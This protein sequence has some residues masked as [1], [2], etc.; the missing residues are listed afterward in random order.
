MPTIALDLQGISSYT[1]YASGGMRE[2]HVDQPNVVHTSCGDLVPRYSRPDVRS[3]DMKSLSFYESGAIRS[4]C[5]DAQTM[6]DTPLG[7]FPAELVTFFE[8]GVLDSVFPLNGQIGFS[9]SQDDEKALADDFTFEF[10]F[11]SI[12]AKI[13]GVRFY[14]SGK[15]KSVILWPGEVVPV[16]TP[17]GV[18]QGRAGVRVFET[19]ELESFEPAAP[20]SLTTP[21]GPVMAYDVDALEMDADEN[22]VRFDA[23]GN[24]VRVATS[25]D[26]IANSPAVGHKRFSSRTRMALSKDVPVK[27]PISITFG[28]DT[29][30]ISNDRQTEAFVISQS[31]FLVLPDI[32][33]MGLCA[34]GC[35]TCA[36]GCVS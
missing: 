35:D 31:R 12:T 10:G 27:L 13:I 5:L 14:P 19:G 29:V 2:C 1:T 32:D 21:I 22:S 11:G 34:D 26:V 18:F 6:V 3:K 36:L 23:T 20:V 33:V 9:W 4:I 25:G 8:D 28:N 15:V 24:L 7:A 30:T 16:A 17:L